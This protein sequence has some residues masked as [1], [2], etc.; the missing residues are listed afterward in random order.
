[1]A[2]ISIVLNGPMKVE[3]IKELGQVPIGKPK[4]VAGIR[5]ANT[6]PTRMFPKVVG[7]AIKFN[8]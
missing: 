6:R 7:I 8:Q 3:M 4:M 1:M 5:S 2:L